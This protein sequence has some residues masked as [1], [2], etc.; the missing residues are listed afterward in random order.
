MKLG[1][2]YLLI[3]HYI[4]LCFSLFEE[5][6]TLEIGYTLSFYTPLHF[7]VA[8]QK[9]CW[10]LHLHLWLG[11]SEEKISLALTFLVIKF[12][13]LKYLLRF[14]FFW[15]TDFTFCLI[16]RYFSLHT[17]FGMFYSTWFG[18]PGPFKFSSLEPNSFFIFYWIFT[19]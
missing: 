12:N 13:C 11:Q 9:K 4:S 18:N 19:F 17:F 6:V 7:L 8:F 3:H 14:N 10:L 2:L 5:N 15:R 16:L 1:L